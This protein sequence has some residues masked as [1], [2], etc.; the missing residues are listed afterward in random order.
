MLLKLCVFKF[1]LFVLQLTINISIA[2]N[3]R[4]KTTT[5]LI[6]YSIDKKKEE[7][8]EELFHIQYGKTISSSKIEP[9][10]Y[11]VLSSKTPFSR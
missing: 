9:E 2:K 6:K 1:P 8:F 7:K 3:S 4:E 10:K 11:I 5:D